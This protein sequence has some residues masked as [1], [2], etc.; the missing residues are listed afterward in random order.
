MFETYI[1]TLTGTNF[2]KGPSTSDAVI[3]YV[4]QGTF[5]QVLG[6]GPGTWYKARLENGTVGYITSLTKYVVKDNPAWLDKAIELIKYGESYLDTDYEFGSKRTTDTTFDC[7][8]FVQWCYEHVGIDLPWDSRSQATVGTS[9][10]FSSLDNLRTG[11][12]LHFDLDGDGVIT[13]CGMYV[14]PRMMLHTNSKTAKIYDHDLHATG[15]INGVTFI[16]FAEGTYW[17]KKLVAVRRN[18]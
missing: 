14:H 4:P 13:H 17:P 10:D 6:E 9:V 3:A 8:D 16:S 5:V 15:G 18:L 7:S 12:R 11:D 2:R 1:R